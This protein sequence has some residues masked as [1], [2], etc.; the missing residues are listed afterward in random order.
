[1]VKNVGVRESLHATLYYQLSHAGVHMPG[2]Q[3]RF[4]E[5]VGKKAT[6]T[7]FGSLSYNKLKVKE[8]EEEE[9]CPICGEPLV[10][11]KWIHV[12]RPPPLPEEEGEYFVD[13]DG[14]R[15]IKLGCCG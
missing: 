11:L 14:W 13:P 4:F 15:E 8:E 10:A 9:V 1:M 2:D 3:A 5:R 12:D 7:W 6:I